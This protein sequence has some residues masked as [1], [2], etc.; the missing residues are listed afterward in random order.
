[1]SMYSHTYSFYSI[2]NFNPEYTY[3]TSQTERRI[4]NSILI[5]SWP[6]LFITLLYYLSFYQYGYVLGLCTLF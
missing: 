1:M 4:E 5:V 2:L 3:D 6:Y